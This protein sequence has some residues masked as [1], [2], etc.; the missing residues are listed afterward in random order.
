MTTMQNARPRGDGREAGAERVGQT[1]A[2]V[3]PPAATWDHRTAYRRRREA[4]LRLPPL[5]CGCRDPEASVHRE[6]RCR[7]RRTA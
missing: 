5:Y 2:S 3:P 6:G 4:A 7:R 1:T